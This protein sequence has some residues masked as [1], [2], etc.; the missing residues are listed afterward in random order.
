M[1]KPVAEK[2][3]VALTREDLIARAEGLIPVLA[4][5]SAECEKARS[6]PAAT[7]RDFIDLGLLRVCQ[8]ARYGGYELGYD[9][10]CEIS[11]TLARGCG[12]Q[13]WVHMVLADNPL[14]L[15]AFS[16]EAQDEVW[17]VNSAAKI[18]VAVAAVGKATRAKGGVVW[19][20]VHGFS[21]GIDHADWVI[22]GGHIHEDGKAPEGC[23]ALIPTKDVEIIDD[24]HAVGLAG[25][26]SKSFAVKDVFVPAHR[27]LSKTDYDNGTSPG[28]L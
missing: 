12:S 28:T 4:A 5:R 3:D 17:G 21:S 7:I 23:F 1:Q 25:T 10:L 16:L 2:A 15:S 24:W 14:K 20:A 19:N 13:A 27:V 22:C 8:P 11:Q 6:A 18:C 9:V 26:G